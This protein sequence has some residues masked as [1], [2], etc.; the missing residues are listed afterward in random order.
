L[1]DITITN[2]EKLQNPKWK[3]HVKHEV[4]NLDCLHCI[5]TERENSIPSQP[6]QAPEFNDEGEQ[7]G[8]KTVN[9][10]TID[11]GSHDDVRG[12]SWQ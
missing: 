7:I 2:P 6:F 9:T 4:N 1:A 5:Y 11:Y 8:T 12:W 3:N 10:I